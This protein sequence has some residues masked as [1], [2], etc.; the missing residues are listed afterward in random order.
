LADG[1]VGGMLLKD[2]GCLHAKPPDVPEHA[3]SLASHLVGVICDY[4]V[5]PDLPMPVQLGENEKIVGHLTPR[6]HL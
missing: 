5:R 6:S 1:G 3:R 4:R 2:R